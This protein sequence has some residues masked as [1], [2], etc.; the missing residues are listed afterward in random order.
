MYK[1]LGIQ[2][3]KD[4]ADEYQPK[5]EYLSP[6]QYETKYGKVIDDKFKGY[7]PIGDYMLNDEAKFRNSKI[8]PPIQ[9]EL[10]GKYQ[11]KSDYTLNSTFN[12]YKTSAANTYALT[13]DL[14]AYKDTVGKTY[15]LKGDYALNSDL[16]AYKDTVGKTYQLKGDYALNSDLNAYKDTVGKTYQLK[17]DY[18]LNSD[19]NAYKD[20]VGKTYQPKGDYVT[21]SQFNSYTKDADT[22]FNNL[23]RFAGTTEEFIRDFNQLKNGLKPAFEEIEGRAKRDYLTKE[24]YYKMLNELKP[25]FEEIEGRAKR[26]YLTKE[27]YY[28]MLNELK[29]AFQEIEGRARRDYLTK[30]EFEAFKV[31][32]MKNVPSIN[33]AFTPV[34]NL[35]PPSY[36]RH[37]NYM[38]Y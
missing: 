27:E 10:D 13:S 28:K 8:W 31:K 20:T 5:G 38:H 7:L 32:L 15:Q 19:L 35:S 11:P 3:R 29:P 17:G 22:K 4:A 37:K 26:D 23:I 16:N 25:A 33:E 24:E 30:E 18:A 12:A 21:L 34:T 1:F 9:A 6:S 36:L 2:S 14:N